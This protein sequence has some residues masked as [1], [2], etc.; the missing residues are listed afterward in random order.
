MTARQFLAQYEYAVERIHRLQEEY[1]EESLLI[2]AVRSLSD[3]DGM[4]HGSGISKPTERKAL[5]LASK[6]Q[7]LIDAR[8]DAI[9]IRQD[10]FDTIMLIDGLE[11]DVL[12]ER[13][14]Y[15]K[16]WADVCEAVH[17]TWPTVRAAWHRGEDRLQKIIDTRYYIH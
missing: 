10:V 4:P 2:D 16:K 6:M 14:I 8:L 3:N 9:R 5:R 13:Y 1:E 11:R 17:F 12:I 15:L 7:R